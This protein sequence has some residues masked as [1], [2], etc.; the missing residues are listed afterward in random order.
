MLTT[1]PVL[2]GM[3]SFEKTGSVESIAQGNHKPCENS[4]TVQLQ[5]QTDEYVWV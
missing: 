1:L 3:G 5:L 4:L 2:E